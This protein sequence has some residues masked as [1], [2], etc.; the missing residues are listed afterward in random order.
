MERKN[1]NFIGV[2]ELRGINDKFP[3]LVKEPGSLPFDPK[4]LPENQLLI[5]GVSQAQDGEKLTINKMRQIFGWDPEKSEPCFYNQDWYLKESFAKDEVLEDRW[6][7][8]GKTVVEE[9]RG[10]SPKEI[11]SNLGEKEQLPSAILTAFTFF[12]YYLLTG[13]EMLWKHDFVWCSDKDSNGDRIYTGRY[14]DPEK[15]NRDGFNVHRHLSLKFC[16]GG[17]FQIKP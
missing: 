16:F 15:I 6:Y 7:L 17:T 13:G 2:E 9:T 4:E 12:S 1:L 8:I 5:L 14:L 3:V 10:K 11:L